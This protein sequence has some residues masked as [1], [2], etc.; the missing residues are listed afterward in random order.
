MNDDELQD[1]GGEPIE[2]GYNHNS[3]KLHSVGIAG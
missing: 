1:G 2:C 3:F